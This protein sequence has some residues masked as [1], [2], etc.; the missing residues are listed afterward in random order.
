MLH[1][2]VDSAKAIANASDKVYLITSDWQP[3][4]PVLNI[5]YNQP[6]ARS[7]ALSRSDVALSAMAYT[8]GVPVGSFYDGIEK[9]QIYV[10]CT[11]QDGRH[12]DDINSARVFGM[13][14]TWEPS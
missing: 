14:L 11:D 8:G 10:K 2:L 9:E 7:S 5:A 6:S 12:I 3:Q 4:V 1:Q 13:I